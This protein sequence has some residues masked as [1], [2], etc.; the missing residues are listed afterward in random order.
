MSKKSGGGSVKSR[1]NPKASKKSARTRKNRAKS[2][3]KVINREPEPAARQFIEGV[4]IRGEASKPSPGGTLPP[5]ITHKIVSD[6]EEELPAI[7]REGF[8]L[9]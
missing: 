2:R 8:S 5:D 6:E 1:S 3:V 4:L 7:E 9:Y